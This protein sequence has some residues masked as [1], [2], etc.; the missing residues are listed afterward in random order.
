ME[1]LKLKTIKEV[2][3]SLELLSLKINRYELAIS[4]KKTIEPSLYCKIVT[5]LRE[6]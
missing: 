3:S 2:I 5:T 1:S 6:V 4:L